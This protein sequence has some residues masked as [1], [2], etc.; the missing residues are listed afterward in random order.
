VLLLRRLVDRDAAIRLEKAG[1]GRLRLVVT[2]P[3]QLRSI[4]RD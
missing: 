4:P 2:R 1:R 3:L